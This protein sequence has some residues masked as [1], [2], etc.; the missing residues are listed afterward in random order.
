MAVFG[1]RCVRIVDGVPTG[2]DVFSGTRR[3]GA[4]CVAAQIG[5]EGSSTNTGGKGPPENC[6]G[7]RSTAANHPEDGD[8]TEGGKLIPRCPW[9]RAIA[10]IPE[11]DDRVWDARLIRG[12]DRCGDHFTQ[13]ENEQQVMEKAFGN[14]AARRLVA[15]AL[16][17]NYIEVRE[18][19]RVV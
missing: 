18:K 15:I 1:D 2:K 12:G 7:D 5:Q 10:E 8:S 14:S 13:P 19:S 3:T 17:H 6:S 16:A 11:L 9:F 4:S